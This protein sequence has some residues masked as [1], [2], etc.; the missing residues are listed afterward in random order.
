VTPTAQQLAQAR[1]KL[2]DLT[3]R[4]RLL[5]YRPS[6]LRSVSVIGESPAEIFEA[7]VLKEKPLTFRATRRHQGEAERAAVPPAEDDRLAGEEWQQMEADLR[8][9]AQTDKY[10]DTPLDADGLAKKLF[11]VYHEGHTL[12]E[13]Q[14]YSVVHLALGFLEWYESDDSTEVRR[15]PL[16]LVPAELERIAAGDFSRVKWTGEEVYANISLAAKVSEQGVVLPAFA[17]PEEKSGIDA[18][19]GEV[20]ASIARRPRWRVTTDVV[21]D[22][23]SF[24][25]FV[26]YKDLDSAAW[27]PEKKPEDHPLLRSLFEPHSPESDEAGFDEADVDR[28]LS[29]HGAMHV[30]DADPSQIAVIEDA[31]AGWNLVVEGP[32]GTGKS[33]TITNLIAETLAAGKSVLFVSEKM[34]ALEVV[35]K[36]LDR[37]GLAPFCLELHSRKTNKKAVLE[38]LRQSLQSTSPAAPANALYEEHEQLKAE[39]NAYAAELRRP[40]GAS[41]RSAYEALED[42]QRA[43]AH[44][45][46]HQR[47]IPPLPQIPAAE[48]LSGTDIAVAERALRDVGYV[49]PLVSPVD[50][51][52]WRD[53]T[54]ELFLPADV[55]EVRELLGILRNAFDSLRNAAEEL[56]SAAG[57]APPESLDDV[58]HVLRAAA[59]MASRPGGVERDLLLNEAWNAPNAAAEALIAR[60]EAVRRDVVKHRAIFSDEALACDGLADRL[61]EFRPLAAR[62]F[63]IFSGRYRQLRREVAALFRE[64]TPSTAAM[65]AQLEALAG[66][67]RERQE[68]RDAGHGLFGVAWQGADSDAPALRQLSAWLVSFR[69]ELVSQALDSSAVDLVLRGVDRTR[70]ESA[71]HTARRS[72]DALHS[73]LA[74]FARAAGFD[75]SWPSTIAAAQLATLD[76]QLHAWTANVPSLPR[77]AQFNAARKALRQTAAAPVEP[78]LLSGAIVADD[79]SALFQSA[80]ADSLLRRAFAERPAL[81]RFAGEAHERKV[82]RFQELDRKLMELNSAR[83]LRRLH[84]RRPLLRGGVAPSSE[85]G[86]LLGELNRRRNHLPIRQLLIRAGQLVQRIKPCFLMSPLSVA[87]YLDA[88]SVAFDLIV[89]DEA[90]QVRPEDALGALLRGRQLVVMGDSKQLPP[91]S[92]FDHLVDDAEIAAEGEDS[93]VS[94]TEVES[95]LHQCKRSYPSKHLTWHYRSQHD[96][97]IAVSNNLFYENRLRA[98]PSAFNEHDDFGLHFHHMPGTVYD[99]GRSG[100]NRE[101]AKAVARAAIDHFRTWG[102]RRSLGIATFNLKQQ[103]TIHEEIELEL[104]AHPELEP[105]FKSDRAEHFFVKNLETIQGDERDVIFI[106]VG[107]GRD[108][109]GRLTMNFGPLNQ[110]RGERRLNVLI[111][112]S[113]MKCVVFSNFTHR[114]VSL[115]STSSRGVFALKS[116]L[117]FAETRRLVVSDLPQD[118]TDSPFEDAVYAILDAHGYVVRKQVGCA[119][120]RIDLAI[121]DPDQPGAYLLGIE[122]DG[123]KYH[124]SPVAR[125]RDRLRQQILEGLGWRIHRIWSTDWYRNRKETVDRLLAA[126]ERASSEKHDA[127]PGRGAEPEVAVPLKLEPATLDPVPRPAFTQRPW[128]EDVSVYEEC[129]RIPDASYVEGEPW[130]VA[131]G[132]EEVVRVEGPIHIDE[133]VRR[134]SRLHGFSKAGPR[135]RETIENAVHMLHTRRTI[136]RSRDFVRIVGQPVRLRRRN[137]A[138]SAKIDW[139][140]RDEIALAVQRALEVQFTATPADLIL[141]ASRALGFAAT[142]DDTHRTIRDVLEQM[143]ATGMLIAEG[144]L[145]RLAAPP[146]EPA[147]PPRPSTES[148]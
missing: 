92:F 125:D 30:T 17:V 18:W 103:Q 33:Q 70:V 16:L 126:V 15:A 54:I 32:P 66:L 136:E 145:V 137:G 7:L 14:G 115:E 73:G 29:S 43:D 55:E 88:K 48:S 94:V 56:H 128:W 120:Y 79:L 61:E 144:Q 44:F 85:A 36:R 147:Q 122:C 40:I 84:E 23:F 52:V 21:L 24:T 78:V 77:W 130:S 95:I 68:L 47:T 3:L 90:S 98:F 51:H 112:R 107:Y 82:A 11:H 31:K 60:V 1:E 4:N 116:F 81:A 71:A 133:L 110:E 63:R 13:E 25:K 75:T 50:T 5:N 20:K 57:V 124:S 109:H 146:P 38:E 102:D 64:K 100:T 129:T 134:L 148:R 141:Q 27:P 104:R 46:K 117:E 76:T 119:G 91:T 127:P 89:F 143:I 93:T 140:C 39:L 139:I 118:D 10:L 101:E 108:V 99:R 111:S 22:F 105:F 87:Q 121:A 19:L 59:V 74:Q 28:K 131:P 67:Q 12:I 106:S 53:S 34:A 80:L 42:R 113:R 69:R 26:M 6:K 2:L 62:F 132:V 135:I 72:L 138:R 97:L 49:L 9:R 65:V 86:I 8:P 45:E 35:K 96:S 114:D 142:H 41:G 58:E 123:A 83:L 37:A